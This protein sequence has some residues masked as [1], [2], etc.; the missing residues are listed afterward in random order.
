MSGITIT[1]TVFNTVTVGG[2]SSYYNVGYISGPDI[3]ILDLG[4]FVTGEYGVELYGGMMTNAGTV[5]GG[6]ISTGL[7]MTGGTFVN[8]G[9]LSGGFAGLNFSYRAGSAALLHGGVLSNSG[10]IEI[11]IGSHSASSQVGYP[12]AVEILGGTLI[13]TGL[14]SMPGL[15]SGTQPGI[16]L[17]KGQ[18]NNYGSVA[19]GV[20][21]VS[22][23]LVNSGMIGGP[24][25]TTIASI[26]GP[27]G[28]Y[29]ITGSVSLVNT[30]TIDG[31][32][33][34]GTPYT[35]PVYVT[36]SGPI[37]GNV[38][39][40][41]NAV[42][43][44]EPGAKIN[45]SIS[46]SPDS[47]T[48]ALAGNGGSLDV[49]E[50]FFGLGVIQFDPG[51]AWTLGGTA[52]ELAAGQ[53]IT[54]FTLGDTIVLDGFSEV[55][56]AFTPGIGLVLSTFGGPNV[57]LDIAGSFGAGTGIVE[58]TSGGNTTRAVAPVV[59]TLST[60]ISHGLYL[61]NPVYGSPFTI[62]STGT[63][64]AQPEKYLGAGLLIGFR[65]VTVT[66]MGAIY[67]ATALQ[68]PVLLNEYGSS[69]GILLVSASDVLIDNSGRITGGQG[70]A[71]VYFAAYNTFIN[72]GIISGG[73]GGTINANGGYGVGGFED[74]I[75]NAGT[76]AGGAAGSGPSATSGYALRIKSSTLVVEPGAVFIGAVGGDGP[77]SGRDEL[78]LAG[79]TSGSLDM[80]G[81]FSGFDSISF[82]PGAAWTLEGTAA[83]L[84][85]GQTITGLA[86]GDTLVLDG[87]SDTAKNFVTGTG[88]ELGSETIDITGSFTTADFTVTTDGT[89]TTIT[90]DSAPCFC[91]GTRIR[92]PGGKIPVEELR[93]GDLVKSMHGGFSAVKWIGR[94]DYEGR[95]IAGN[96]LALPVRIR[97]HA[98][99]F[100]VPSRDLF[101]SPDHAI[102][103]G[104]V[105][106]Y[107]RRLV[108]GV[109]IVQVPEVERVAY[110]HVELEKHD[111]IFAENCPAESFLDARCR[112]RFQNA[113]EFHALYSQ[114]E[115]AAAACLPRVDGGFY[116]QAIWERI[117]RRAGVV[118]PV[119]ENGPLRGFVDEAGPLLVRGWAQDV[120]APEVPVCLDVCVSGTRVGRVLANLY[121]EDVRAAGHGNGYQG[122]EFVL[123]EG[124][125]GVV[126]VRR[127]ADGA[128]LSM[129]DGIAVRAA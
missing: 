124:C 20:R 54:G 84:A 50:S 110:F 92:T 126:E 43:K 122:F 9:L 62:T 95:F 51:A 1:G 46:A 16:V 24:I 49:S 111:V 25:T 80:G 67:G 17:Y 91:A 33:T 96:H 57:T 60:S 105:L 58:T 48:L 88:L 14:V 32:V 79:S 119:A 64:M 55:G 4:H 112:D 27:N 89:N 120:L 18:L 102:C 8:E 65:A 104:G 101:V 36:D 114:D 42:L 108:N 69:D 106:I 23:T 87:F 72:T 77:L 123:P 98:L 35:E 107:A 86:V 85:A 40:G 56:A 22:G 5:T 129:A 74:L 94:R 70:E 118:V 10:T 45:G 15:Y 100:N 113:A 68:P 81:S 19:N 59:D 37:N 75:I 7:D 93:I 34:L 97:R 2:G 128:G 115:V 26:D 116:L 53:S 31:G 3:Y 76:I 71:G 47:L 44:L 109:S 30:G 21:F 73:A 41:G 121:R 38:E 12:E 29:V 103:E 66:N 13:N 52:A 39:L 11:R 83:A 90:T 82:A 78:V 28:Y 127:A 61:D 117:A 63:I 99:A 6:D 125:A